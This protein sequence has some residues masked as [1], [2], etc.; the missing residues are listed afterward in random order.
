VSHQFPVLVTVVLTAAVVV[1]VVLD[2]TVLEV[3]AEVVIGVWVSVVVERVVDVVVEVAQDVKTSDTTIRQGNTN[4]VILFF[5]HSSYFS[6]V[7]KIVL[8][9]KCSEL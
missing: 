2:W 4:H 7:F 5:I 8:L 1:L 9:I 3:V 6:K